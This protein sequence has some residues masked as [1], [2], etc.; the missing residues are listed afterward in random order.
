[1]AF[2][3]FAFQAWAEKYGHNPP[4]LKRD[5]MILVQARNA[6]RDEERSRA[7]WNAYLTENDPF[8]EGHPTTKF[9]GNLPKW[10][11]KARKLAKPI[12]NTAEEEINPRLALLLQVERELKGRSTSE[13]RIEFA[14]RAA[15]QFPVDS[16]G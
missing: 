1:M 7:A 5:Y 9:I 16:Q 12:R 14:R 13:I 15:L 4:W 10:E 8:Y 3:D 6:I 11:A 2:K